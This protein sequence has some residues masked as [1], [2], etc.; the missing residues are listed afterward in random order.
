MAYFPTTSIQYA[1]SPS[2]DAFDRLRI[3]APFAVF[4]TKQ[5]YT[6]QS[7]FWSEKILVR[8]H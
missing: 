4:S 3:S 7:L 2:I 8:Y 1:D 5:I 6:D